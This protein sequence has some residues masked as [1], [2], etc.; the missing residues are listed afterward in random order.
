MSERFN[1]ASEFLESWENQITPEDYQEQLRRVQED[2]VAGIEESI[3]LGWVT[4]EDGDQM[5]YGWMQHFHIDSES[6]GA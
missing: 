1:R 2:M 6:S 4:R 3:R 5:L